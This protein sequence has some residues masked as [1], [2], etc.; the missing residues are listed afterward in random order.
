M[1]LVDPTSEK[2]CIHG[3]LCFIS[4]FKKSSIIL[5]FKKLS[6]VMAKKEL[7]TNFIKN[8][9]IDDI[10]SNKTKKLITRFPPE[11]NGYLHIGHAKSICLNFELAKEFGGQ[12]NLR[13]D[14][15]NPEKESDEYIKSIQEDVRWLGFSWDKLCFASDYFDQLYDYALKLIEKD[16]AYV[17]SQTGDQIKQSR[18]TLQEPGINSPYRDR[19][20]QENLTL[21]KDMKDG[22]FPDG[23]H[24]LRLKIDMKNSNI[25]MRDPVIYRIKHFRHHR[26][27]DKWCIYP[28]YDFTHC[29]SDAIEGI[30]HSLCTLEFE[31]HRILYDWIIDKCD[32]KNKPRQIEF[33]R[34]ELEN[35]V[36][37]KRKL[38][39]LV[40]NKDVEGWDDPR[41]PTISGLRNKGFTAKSIR[42]F[43][44]RIGITKKNSEIQF[45][46]LENSIRE[47]LNE[48]SPRAFGI[49]KPLKV[50]IINF[51][52]GERQIEAS[53]GRKLILSNE[54]FIDEDD[55]ME[56][57]PEK[58]FRLYPGNTVRLKYACNITCKNVVKNND[59]SI[60]FLEC[61]YDKDSYELTKDKKVKGIIHWLDQ[62]SSVQSVIQNFEGAKKVT[63][64]KAVVEASILNLKKENNCQFER[65]G[66]YKIN[67]VNNGSHE[68]YQIVTLKDTSKRKV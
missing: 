61:E 46:V 9:I 68:C 25:N 64:D 28:M 13:F 62:K 32:I 67:N 59:G 11:P 56:S 47:E 21:F 16:L 19:S 31:D 27:Q 2:T 23:T 37:S 12:C 8:I 1:S 54:I 33:A 17:D 20:V 29:L 5:G 6:L 36:M 63:Y 30:T 40:N 51:D 38:N 44:G 35:C 7:Q 34:L 66:Y 18:G 24:V 4:G 39:E 10:K 14:D 48:S 58:Y 50:K 22:K 55:F 15:T 26:T 42:D 3:I 41:M 60:D 57:P 52:E 45:S 65:V 49:L 43:C 53:N